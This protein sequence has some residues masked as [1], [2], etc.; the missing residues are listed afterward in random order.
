MP[1]KHGKKKKWTHP[2]SVS[3]E[4]LDVDYQEGKALSMTV[5][6]QVSR[7]GQR[8]VAPFSSVLFS[9]AGLFF[10]CGCHAPF[11]SAVVIAKILICHW[12]VDNRFISKKTQFR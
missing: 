3:G 9:S 8:M 2:V 5:T 7:W 1:G 11:S 10:T 6:H 4:Y 12:L